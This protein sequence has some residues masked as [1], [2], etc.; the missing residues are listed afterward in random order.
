VSRTRG[1]ILVIRGGAIGDFILTLPALA[2]LRR[3]FP[4]TSV[5]LLGY[6]KLAELAQSAGIIDAY[7]AIEARPLAGFFARR[8]TLDPATSE[9]FPS[10]AVVVSYLYDPDEIFKTN[11]LKTTT[12]QFVE[13]P[14][15]PDEQLDVH[16]V[17]VFL[18]PL[19][20]FAIFD[21]DPIPRLQLRTGETLP[22][23]HWLAAHPGS[24]SAR[25][26][27]S[28]PHWSELLRRLIGETEWNVLLVGGEAEEGRAARLAAQ[29]PAGRVHCVENLPLADL[30]GL[31][32]QTRAFIGHDSGITHVA[33]ALG[34]PLLALWGES[35]AQIWRPRHPQARILETALK[36]GLHQLEVEAVFDQLRAL[37]APL[38]RA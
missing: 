7:R 2:A 13:G 11:V 8:G 34:I 14:H 35:N 28:E 12:A 32:Q 15:R 19:E 25:K 21:A 18:K 31:L 33:A 4:E 6:P 27:W 1:K 23:G 24:G 3:T 26:N 30:A 16:A 20:K 37:V 10:F 38:H 9:Y 22:P 29:L 5:E 36:G 17:D